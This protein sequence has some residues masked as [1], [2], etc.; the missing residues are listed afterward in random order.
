VGIPTLKARQRDVQPNRGG[1]ESKRHS[2]LRLRDFVTLA[3]ASDTG[4]ARNNFDLL[5]LFAA[6]SVVFAHSFD[7]LKIPQPFSPLKNVGWGEIGVLIFFSI[8]GFLVTRSWARDPRIV[9]FVVKRS[10]RLMPGL[11][12]ALLLSALVLGPVVT[13]EPLRIYLRDPATKAYILN[14]AI[15][16]S[17]FV[18]PGV[19]AHTVY[20]LAV[21][22]S[23]WT[24]PLEVKAYLVVAVMG[25][26]ALVLRLKRAVIVVPVAI[27]ATLA[28][29]NGVRPSLP[30][31]DHLVAWLADVQM[32]PSVVY[33]AKI[34]ALTI[35]AELFAAFVIGA[36]LYSLR[37][38]VKLRWDLAAAAVAALVGVRLFD[39]Q[40]PELAAVILLPYIVLCL[41]Y[42]TAG[43]VRLPRRFGDYSYGIYIY[44]FPVQ[45]TISFLVAPRSGWMMFALALPAA[46]ALAVLSWHVVER[47]ALNMKRRLAR[48]EPDRGQGPA[49]ADQPTGDG[50]APLDE[51]P[52]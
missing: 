3:E 46:V 50:A 13:S 16:Q 29:V 49:V 6:T 11:V 8:S 32:A 44:A 43:M 35:Y 15:M 41:A 22:G 28:C 36:G 5:R 34:G 26:L 24:L 48:A 17:D 21:N 18:L 42:L 39:G 23:L 52:V 47:P 4:R 45:Q 2:R 7:L 20:P 51:A 33:S 27:F 40:V 14:N 1:S 19:F 10:L 38:S 25:V 12:V 30:A 37:A 9:P 31:A